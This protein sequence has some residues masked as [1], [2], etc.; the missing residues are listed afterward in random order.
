MNTAAPVLREYLR[1]TQITKS[2]FDVTPASSLDD[3]AA[4]APRHP[5]FLVA[6]S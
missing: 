6:R 2:F 4:E 1:T 5:V 3:F